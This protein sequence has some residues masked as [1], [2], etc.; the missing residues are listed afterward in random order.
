MLATGST[1][2]PQEFEKSPFRAGESLLGLLLGLRLLGLGLGSWRGSL[3]L[4]GLDS[5]RGSLGLSRVGIGGLSSSWLGLGGLGSSRGTLLRLGVVL[6]LG[7]CRR[8][9]TFL[10]VA[11]ARSHFSGWKEEEEEWERRS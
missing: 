9:A 7:L 5:R 6:L 11:A 4:S 3:R 1:L 2:Q 8:N 10:G